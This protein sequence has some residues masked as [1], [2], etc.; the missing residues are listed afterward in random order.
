LLK[1][2]GIAPISHRGATPTSSGDVLPELE[3]STRDMPAEKLLLTRGWYVTRFIFTLLTGLS[4]LVVFVFVNKILHQTFMLACK[5]AVMVGK[6]SSLFV[7]R[8]VSR[9]GRWQENRFRSH[10]RTMQ[11]EE[12]RTDAQQ[13]PAALV[14]IVT[15]S[16]VPKLRPFAKETWATAF[17]SRDFR[18]FWTFAV[19]ARATLSCHGTGQTCSLAVQL[20]GRCQAE[21]QVETSM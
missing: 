20:V 11:I 9:S 17:H 6:S 15:A 14:V 13:M 7:R 4:L 12:I 18:Q 2:E 19:N 21:K 16:C 10:S 1:R 5:K 3:Q 8:N